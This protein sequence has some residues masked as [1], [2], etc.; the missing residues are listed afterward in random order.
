MKTQTRILTAAALASAL[1]GGGLVAVAAPPAELRE[2]NLCNMPAG[3]CG[4]METLT[5]VELGELE[6]L[7][8]C[9]PYSPDSCYNVAQA[10]ACDP[11]A[12]FLV[13]CE[14]GR[15]I[16]QSGDGLSGFEC[17]D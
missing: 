13:Y 15:S 2:V 1:V 16:A 10:A 14:H 4:A 12:E 7:F 6:E 5:E 17:F 3:R 11:D 9:C 8:W